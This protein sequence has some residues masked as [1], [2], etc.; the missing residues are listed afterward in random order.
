MGILRRPLSYLSSLI[1]LRNTRWEI[2]SIPSKAL[3]YRRIHFGYVINSDQSITNF[4]PTPSCF[5]DIELSCDWNRYSTPQKT[6]DLIGKEYKTSKKGGQW[7]FKNQNDF[8]IVSL[9]VKA[10]LENNL[11]QDILHNP[12]QHMPEKTGYPNNRAHS[13]VKGEK[14]GTEA[15]HV[16]IRF[17]LSKI[18]KW[19]IFDETRLKELQAKRK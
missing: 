17:W 13:L 8:F 9:S 7:H 6:F 14:G 12:I 2:E 16:K 4:I 3:L 5:K 10:M 11:K 19:E 18:S 15:E 1:G